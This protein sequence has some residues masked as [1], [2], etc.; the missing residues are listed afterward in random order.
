MIEYP[1]DSRIVF[2]R[3]HIAAHGIVGYDEQL[4]EA[5]DIIARR[6]GLYGLFTEIFCVSTCF[7]CHHADFMRFAVMYFRSCFDQSEYF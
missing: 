5:V 7:L 4:G 3:F 1:T 6:I 2:H